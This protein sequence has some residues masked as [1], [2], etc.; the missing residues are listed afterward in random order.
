[1]AFAT[2][3][4]DAGFRQFIAEAKTAIAHSNGGVLSSQATVFLGTAAGV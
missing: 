4:F 2:S 3:S 1:M